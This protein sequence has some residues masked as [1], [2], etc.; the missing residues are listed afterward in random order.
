MEIAVFGA[1][2][3][4]TLYA[5]RLARV[6]HHVTII[7]RGRRA[8]ELRRLGLI[9]RN[10]S[11]GR[12]ESLSLP[13]QETL[14]NDLRAAL[15]FV[16]VRREQ[17]E[18]AVA[19]LERSKGVERFVWM[20]NHVSSSDLLNSRLGHDQVVLGFPGAAG[21]IQD[22]VDV[23]LDIP[24][25]PTTIDAKA[26]EVAALLRAAGFKTQSVRDMNAW[27]KRHAVMITAI[28]CAILAKNGDARAL[29]GDPLLM[30]SLIDAIREAWIALD[31]AGVT[32]APLAL[33][34][35]FQ[36][37]P[38]RFAAEYWRRLLASEKG[39]IYFAQHAR[40]C[41]DETRALA[42]DVKTL[43]TDRNRIPHLLRL[44]SVLST[45]RLSEEPE[46]HQRAD[47]H[48]ECQQN[49]GCKNTTRENPER[50]KKGKGSSTAGT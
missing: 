44:Y 3:Q 28:S 29:A 48:G 36:W 27:L 46:S 9:I 50:D 5:E 22:G 11:S 37:V 25:Q 23:Y 38:K 35:I 12:T 1:G 8:A 24:E 33:R 21:S 39:E 14:P 45:L 6:G 47:C 26:P 10:A 43:I 34:A 40:R 42:I 30:R 15:C 16:F 32:P 17:I 20:G 18:A 41:V 13:I 2:V 31:D 49:Y 7:A 4:G 19:A